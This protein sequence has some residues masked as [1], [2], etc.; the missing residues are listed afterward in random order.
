MKNGKSELSHIS[1]D[2]GA[3][4]ANVGGKSP[5][6]REAVAEVWVDVGTD[7]ARLLAETGGVGKGNV[8]ETARLAGIMAAKKT[9]DLIPM[10]HP[11]LLDVVEVSAELEDC[12]VH[13]EVRVACEGRTGVEMEALTAASVAALTVYDM[14]KSA[15]KGIEIGPLRLLK[16]SGGKSGPWHRGKGDNGQN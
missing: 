15:G 6:H 12:R 5:S 7:I 2:G 4:M 3:R 9:A 13:I 8:L 1:P 14:V 11:L 10:C 16:K